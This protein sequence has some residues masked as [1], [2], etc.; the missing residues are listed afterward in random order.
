MTRLPTA[1]FTGDFAP[2]TDAWYSH[3]VIVHASEG[4]TV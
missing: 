3:S 4:E 2:T 1:K